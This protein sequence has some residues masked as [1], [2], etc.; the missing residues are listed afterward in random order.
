MGVGALIA[1]V[2]S[3]C[4]GSSSGTKGSGGRG[5]TAGA[6]TGGSA[7][8]TASGG[9]TGGSAGTLGE[10]GEAG[11]SATS[12]TG[13]GSG[14]AG[15]AGVMIS[16]GTS[17]Q[18]GFGGAS[19]LGGFVNGGTGGFAG[20]PAG[21]GGGGV[22]GA[23]AGW[24]CTTFAYNDG[25]C[26][27]GCGVPDIDC[28]DGDIDSCEVCSALGSCQSN[29][30]PGNIDPDDTARCIP[31]PPGW[32][33][34]SYYYHDGSCDC[35]CG[36]FDPDCDDA[37]VESCE[38]CSAFGSCAGGV[39]PA[40]IDP[41]DNSTCAV[42]EGWTCSTDLY[43]DGFD[44]DCGC[45]VVDPD[46]AS[47]SVTSC[48]SC[49]HGC[50]QESCP[51]PIDHDNNAICTGVPTNW[52]C[53]VRF[54]HDGVQCNCGCGAHDPDCPDDDVNSCDVCDLDGSC[55]AQAC[56]GLISQIDARYCDHPD[57]P[58]GWTCE[59][60]QYG[61]GSS[62]D[63][64]CGVPDVDCRG[65]SMRDCDS[66]SGCG[67]FLCPGRVDPNDVT[68]CVPPPTAWHCDDKRYHDGYSCD[69]G[70]GA[71]DPDCSSALLE[72]CGYCTPYIG[73]CS[74]YDCRDLDPQNNA[75]CVDDPPPEWTC[76]TEYY[77]DRACDCGCGVVDIDCATATS[78]SCVFCDDPGSC[79][80]GKCSA[81]QIDPNN[82]ALCTAN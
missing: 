26:H 75:R 65:S 18:A 61:D 82:N 51:G 6:S 32:T 40:A 30:C 67:A 60:Y 49:W 25:K 2:G 42:P 44:C 50:S 46:C 1:A 11:A 58:S 69:C 36:A 77:G 64:G 28:K 68:Q 56:P 52:S 31:P 27:C 10:S 78:A 39:C 48:T 80:S 15:A 8:S 7:G 71:L 70:C 14:S 24:S 21:N 20:L 13:G 57:P 12:A 43:N 9:R 81:G 74:D 73:S 34:S 54:F 47:A 72:S 53:P 45:G 63:C 16:G 19:G 33:C 38:V 3:G 35:G 22:A 66:C 59:W 29:S 4:S 17:G 5:G 23:P 79:S 76:N 37:S 62:C 55:S 41:T